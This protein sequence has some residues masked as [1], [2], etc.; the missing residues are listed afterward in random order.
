[1]GRTMV[2]E[3]GQA[4]ELSMSFMLA[5][6]DRSDVVG[7]DSSKSIGSVCRDAHE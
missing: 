3:A 6:S 7:S 5:V 4:G 1:M 2:R